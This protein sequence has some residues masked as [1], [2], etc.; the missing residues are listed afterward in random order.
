[1]GIQR[2]VNLVKIALMVLAGVFFIL[3]LSKGD[4]AI[5]ESAGIQNSLVAPFMGLAYVVLIVAVLAVVLVS[6]MQIV[7]NP[8]AARNSLIGLGVLG[9]L[10]LISYLTASGADYVQYPADKNVTEQMS[11]LSGM[12]LNAMFLSLGAAV[13]SIVYSEV[14][15]FFK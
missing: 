5:E 15:R 9:V 14:T 1:M 11:K 10:L 3:V 7:G 6:V 2:I 13:A 8:K 4:T 12:G